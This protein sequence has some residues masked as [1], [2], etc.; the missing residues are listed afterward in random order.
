MNIVLIGYRGTGKSAIARKLGKRLSMHVVGMDDEI[1][2]RAGKSIPEIVA[3]CGWDRF[4]DIES[5]VAADFGRRDGLIIDAG[6]GVIVRDRN[7]EHLKANGLVVWLVADVQTI[8]DRIKD[9]TQRPSL[10]GSKSFLD[11]VTGI[12]TERNPK[13]EAAADYVVDTARHT[14]EEAADVIAGFFSESK[15]RR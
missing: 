10:S 11:E 12:L 13:Y 14:V 1:I 4:R 6:G 8:I 2:A 15:E 7:I 9:D 5:Q 3:E